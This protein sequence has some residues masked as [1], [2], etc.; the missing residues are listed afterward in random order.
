MTD[1]AIYLDRHGRHADLVLNRPDKRNAVT[2]QMW[3][4]IPALLDEAARD[5]R[6]KLLVVRG[7]GGAFAAGAD[8]SEFESVYATRESAAAY[9]S[10]I[11]TALDRLAQFPKPTL[12]R[13]EGACVGG[14][15][16]IALACD[17]RFAAQGS[18]FG[19]TPAKLGL[20]YTLNDTKRLIDAVG[21]ANAKDILYSGRLVEADEARS[22]G[23]INRL[24]KADELDQHVQAYAD[25]LAATSGQTARTTKAIINMIRSGVSEDTDETRKLFLDAFQST[26]FREG[27]QAFLEKRAPK[28]PDPDE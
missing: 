4:A 7:A 16:G 20:A 22:I 11:A 8:I 18:R 26:D 28:F 25:Q 15:C 1:T 12:A 13:I 6:I 3:S 27:Y 19:I 2:A 14:G 10:S 5:P 17:L 21:V 23:L 9:T 24:V